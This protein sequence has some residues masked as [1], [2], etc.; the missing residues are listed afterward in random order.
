[1]LDS[2][3]FFLKVAGT[4]EI[5]AFKQVTASTWEV[6]AVWPGSSG[7][8]GLVSLEAGAGVI[9]E[10]YV[11]EVG[12]FVGISTGTARIAYEAGTEWISVSSDT[13]F[14]SIVTRTLNDNGYDI[15]IAYD[16]TATTDGLTARMDAV[17]TDVSDIPVVRART[18][19]FTV[20]V[21]PSSLVPS[22]YTDTGVT[23]LGQ[24]S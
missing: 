15:S 18:D 11:L 6:V 1:M 17:E 10:G 19:Q 14:G 16:Y 21:P 22:G 20:L 3:S 2:V 5:H 12:D 13:G 23:L 8:T 9:P 4:Y 24:R 7:S